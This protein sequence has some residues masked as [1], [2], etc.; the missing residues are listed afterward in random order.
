MLRFA[1]S[2]QAIP[3]LPFWAF[4]CRNLSLVLG[5]TFPP[6]C[7]GVTAVTLCSLQRDLP[8][9][10]RS[11]G[12]D[13]ARGEGRARRCGDVS[14]QAPQEAA[15]LLWQ[16]GPSKPRPAR[17]CPRRYGNGGLP[18]KTARNMAA[19]LLSAALCGVRGGRAFGTAGETRAGEHRFLTS[20]RWE[21]VGVGRWRGKSSW[22]PGFPK[23][24]WLGRRGWLRRG[25][26]L[27][28]FRSSR[29]RFLL[30][31]KR[32]LSPLPAALCKRAAPL[33]PMPNE[34]IDVSNL[35]ALEKYRSFSRYFKLAEKESRKPRW[36]KTYRQHTSPQP[37]TRGRSCTVQ[38]CC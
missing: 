30:C 18:L 13:V 8:W 25:T 12:G 37:G 21:P 29:A 31:I 36:W 2:S 20:G 34:D 38:F 6:C 28:L 24:A 9:G 15:P 11:N 3:A 27:P 10:Q 1:R 32:E 26:A 5:F 14:S 19:P 4:F 35:E 23:R 7:P 33:G 16:R 17:R 22:T